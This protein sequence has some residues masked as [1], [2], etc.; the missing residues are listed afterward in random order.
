MIVYHGPYSVR[1]GGWPSLGQAPTMPP[2]P[3]PV[4][5]PV[6]VNGVMMAPPS[7]FMGM[8]TT[9]LLIGAGVVAGLLIL[10]GAL[11]GR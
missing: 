8:P 7:M 9:P 10:S 5:A 2:V 4:P 3:A 6:P 11:A 1:K